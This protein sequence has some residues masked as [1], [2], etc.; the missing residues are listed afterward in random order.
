[1]KKIHILPTN[2]TSR[3][4]KFIDDSSFGIVYGN[5]IP[6]GDYEQFQNIYITNSEEIK[7][8]EWCIGMDG[9]FQYKGKVNL[10]DV[11]LPKKIILTTDQDLIKV[12]VQAIDDEFLEWFVAHS[13][14]EKVEIEQP[15]TP[16]SMVYGINTNLHKIIIPKERLKKILG[17]KQ[18][19]QHTK[20][21]SEN[22]NELFF[23]EKGNLIKEEQCTCRVGEP[24]NNL[25]CKVHGNLNDDF[26]NSLSSFK[27]SL[28][29]KYDDTKW[30]TE[31]II[32]LIQF[33]S[34]N[35]I[36]NGYSSVS[37]Q[38][39]NHFLEEFKKQ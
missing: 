6:V 24:Y 35:E 37:R 28:N 16:S 21:F 14:C 33:L 12:G 1:M 17:T 5:Y 20:V 2:K 8:G 13:S 36:F 31:K 26:E 39:A 30:D 34:M 9:I 23:D 27:T 22:G 19:K 32:D 4:I 10:P 7:D 11:E 38:T 18:P 3:L 29:K 25:C 15:F